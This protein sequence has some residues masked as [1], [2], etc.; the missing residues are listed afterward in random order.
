MTFGPSPRR[1]PAVHLQIGER[2]GQG[3]SLR[4]TIA[5]GFRD[6]PRLAGGL[7]LDE[8]SQ[9]GAQKSALAVE[10]VL[11]VGARPPNG[12]EGLSGAGDVGEDREVGLRHELL[13]F[14]IAT[15]DQ[16]Q[17]RCLNAA[18][19]ENAVVAAAAAEHR[20][21]AGHV[22]AVEPI[23]ALAADSGVVEWFE[24]GVGLNGAERLAH[25]R[26]VHIG[27]EYAI[28]FAAVAEVD[29]DLVDEQLALPVGVAG[30]DDDGRSREEG[31]DV[32]E[33]I[34]RGDGELQVPRRN[35]KVVEPPLLELGVVRLRRGQL[36]DVAGAPGDDVGTAAFEVA[37]APLARLREG[38]GDRASEGRLFGDEQAHG[39]SLTNWRGSE[40]R[41]R[42]CIS[43]PRR[44]P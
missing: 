42:C 23:G 22:E 4:F 40:E 3:R 15:D 28:G 12:G 20:V 13:D 5:Q 10:D 26:R 2:V 11:R 25:R 41:R 44:H 7:A 29:E 9:V 8:R 31:L 34:G 27:D 37:V 18:D 38:F 32:L 35:R 39:W 24:L 36:E 30:V 16:P 21:E 1:R 33:K 43:G 17:E 19:G 6:R 14:E